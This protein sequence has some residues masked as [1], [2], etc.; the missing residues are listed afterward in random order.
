[1]TTTATHYS[2]ANTMDADQSSTATSEKRLE[3]HTVKELR[4]LASQ[5]GIRG[6]SKLMHKE[7]LICVIRRRW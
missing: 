3:D 4:E 5:L 6:R 1:M 2:E 7:E